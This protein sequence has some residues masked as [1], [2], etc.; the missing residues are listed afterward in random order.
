MSSNLPKKTNVRR[1][2]ITNQSEELNKEVEKLL[3]YL[4][5]F[6]FFLSLVKDLPFK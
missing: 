5:K 2:L 3:F 1:K 4:T 6:R